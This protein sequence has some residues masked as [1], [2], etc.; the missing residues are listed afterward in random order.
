MS[1]VRISGWR[2]VRSWTMPGDGGDGSVA[3]DVPAK[4][5][6]AEHEQPEQES[7]GWV[8]REVL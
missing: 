4:E 7:A 8:H 3:R 1:M 5:P 6:E 2:N